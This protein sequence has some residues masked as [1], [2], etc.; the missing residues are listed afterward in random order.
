MQLVDEQ[1]DLPVRI[2]H[3]FEHRLEAL[4][5]LATIFGAGHQRAQVE[6]DH[7]LVAQTLGHVA[8]DDADGQPL[9]DGRLAHAGLAHQHRVVLGAPR[10]HLHHTTNLFIAA[11]DR[12]ELVAAGLLG[13]VASVLGQ[14]LV[15]ALGRGVGDTL[16]AADGR[17]RPQQQL[18]RN[19]NVAQGLAGVARGIHDGQ[20]QVLGGD[21]VVVHAL[22]VLFSGRHHP[23]Q[24]AR[25]VDLRGAIGLGLAR[26]LLG[27]AL[28]QS[29]RR[30]VHLQQYLR[31]HAVALL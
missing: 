16:A 31:H 7:A 11:D 19:T 14:R 22:R 28:Q 3:L 15:G 2:L 1:D 26:Q 29:A 25:K 13:D 23:R 17:E 10:E 18:G 5:E 21:I 20:Q 12:V 6:R 9:E 27:K 4:F 8:L 24:L 30:H